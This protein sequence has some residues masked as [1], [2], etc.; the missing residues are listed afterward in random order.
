MAL[1]PTDNSAL[2][3]E[4]DEAVRKDQ[5]QS[6]AQRYG[7]WVVGVAVAGL[8]AFG[9]Y[10]YWGHHQDSVRGE[11]AEELLA[12]FE[13]LSSGQPQAATSELK[14]LEASGEGAY[15]AAALIQQANMKAEA[16]DLKGAAA[17]MATLAGDADVDPALRDLARIRQTVFEYDTL[18]PEAVI[19]RMK[20]MVDAK[21]PASSWF[22]SAA[23]LSAIAHYQL[24]QY[25][26]AGALYGQIAKLDDIPKSLQ[27]RSVQMAGMLGVDAVADRAEDSAKAEAGTDT[28]GATTPS[29]NGDAE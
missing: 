8:L 18:K 13:K 10:L 23:E 27:S 11:K 21:D 7:R 12:A 6:F 9:G 17:M 14:A 16:G 26:R 25:D 3:Q 22:A 15:R 2:L 1:S 28:K 24:G 29:T 20:P 19:A 5:L 4:V